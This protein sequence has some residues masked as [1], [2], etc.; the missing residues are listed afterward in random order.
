MTVI[1]YWAVFSVGVAAG[2]AVALLY[3]PQTGKKTRKQL[4]S[5]VDDASDYLKDAA[6]DIT[7]Q[8]S[9]YA[10]KA[11]D[12]AQTVASQASNYAAKAADVASDY[13]YK[14][15]DTVEDLSKSASKVAKKVI[16]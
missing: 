13:A 7:N 12:V 11:T 16:S 10:S 1:R 2:A 5:K 4:L 8:A 6:G 15:Q 3:A 14:A 9:R